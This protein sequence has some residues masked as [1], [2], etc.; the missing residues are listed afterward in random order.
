MSFPSLS[1]I[2]QEYQERDFDSMKDLSPTKLEQRPQTLVKL[3]FRDLY[4]SKLS[5][6]SIFDNMAIPL[7]QKM[8]QES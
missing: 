5:I 2:N 1:H 3:R 8:C 7:N 4:Y 6:L